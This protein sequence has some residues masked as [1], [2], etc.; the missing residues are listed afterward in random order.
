MRFFIRHIIVALILFCSYCLSSQQVALNT[1]FYYFDFIVNPS[2]SGYD[3]FNPIYLSYRNQWTGFN[4][5]PETVHFGGSFSLDSK[6][7]LGF[8]FFQDIH[9]G[10][11]RQ[12]G[13]HLNYAKHFSLNQVAVLSLGMGAFVDQFSG[14]FSNLELTN[15]NDNFLSGQQSKLLGDIEF[16]FNLNIKKINI[17]FSAANLL[18][19]RIDDNQG[20]SFYNNLKRQYSLISSYSLE[21]DSNI[22][23]QPKVLVRGLESGIFHTD[24][25]LLGKLKDKYL[26][27]LSHRLNTAFSLIAGIELNGAVI[28][29]SYDL[30]SSNIQRYTGSTHEIVL[31]YKFNKRKHKVP[32]NL[33]FEPIKPRDVIQLKPDSVQLSVFNVD[34]MFLEEIID[35]IQI[36]PIEI[37]SVKKIIREIDD[38]K[39]INL[40][41]NNLEFDFD[42]SSIDKKFNSELVRLVNLLNSY[43]QWNITIEGHTDAKRDSIL[44]KK[45]LLRKGIKYSVEAHNK[46]SKNYNMLLSHRRAQSV[47]TFLIKNGVSKTRIKAIGYGEEKPIASN[48]TQEGRQKNRRVELVIIK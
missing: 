3:N 27:G 29:Y 26:F 33:D 18:Q 39:K 41:F 24:F 31:G 45:I 13:M 1:Q 47:V 38:E 8:Q 4:G 35:P 30:A 34:S 9:G 17:G 12:S 25:I 15:N 36:N 43:P 46:L 44:A 20:N 22:A 19:S 16:G 32:E 7:A 28:S 37:D 5:S 23:L 6:N 40:I 10:A 14:D 21:I 42:K 11:Y 48:A 2:L